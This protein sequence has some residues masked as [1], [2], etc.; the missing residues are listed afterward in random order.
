MILTSA[1][2]YSMGPLANRPYFQPDLALFP[3]RHDVEPRPARNMMTTRNN[4][5]RLKL[6]NLLFVG[7]LPKQGLD[8]AWLYSGAGYL[9]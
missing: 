4:P 5:D 9:K 2:K 6:P 3:E 7:N 1:A 8:I